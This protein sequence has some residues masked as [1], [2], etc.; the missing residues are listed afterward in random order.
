VRRPR[1]HN[2]L[3]GVTG[4]I[5]SGKTLV[6]RAFNRL[7]LPVLYADEIAKTVSVVNTSVRREIRALLGADAYHTDG[8]LNRDHISGLIFSRPS[9]HKKLN[10]IVHPRVKREVRRAARRLFAQGHRIVIV[11]AALIYESRMDRM[12]DYVIVVDAPRQERI[13]RVLRRD[14]TSRSEVERRMRAQWSTRAKRRLA[15]FILENSGSVKDLRS[16]V[17][18]LTSLFIRISRP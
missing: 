15:D 6:C 3:V 18:L 7:G 4:G 17:K 12:L 16:A 9:L 14:G 5:G 11:E 8:S 13:R 1:G 2:L 10:A